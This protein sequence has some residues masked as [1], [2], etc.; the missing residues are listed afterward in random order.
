MLCLMVV[1][2]PKWQRGLNARVQNTQ[3]SFSC[4]SKDSLRFLW[5]KRNHSIYINRSPHFIQISP[6]FPKCPFSDI[7]PHS[8]HDITFSSC[9]LTLSKLVFSDFL[10]FDDLPVLRSTGQVFCRVSLNWDLFDVFLMMRL[11]SNDEL[12]FW[13]RILQ[14]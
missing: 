13:G 9:L 1:L 8:G 11:V 10:I 12:W 2:L 5:S 3:C 4:A 14:R 7:R 6:V